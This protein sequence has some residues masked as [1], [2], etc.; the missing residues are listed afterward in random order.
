MSKRNATWPFAATAIVCLLAAGI[1]VAA[2]RARE[3]QYAIS[4]TNLTRAQIIS[5]VT[6]FTHT[7]DAEPLFSIGS[8]ASPAL[9]AVA[10]DADASGLMETLENDPDV[11]DIATLTGAEGPLMPGETA[12]VTMAAT[13][14]RQRVSLAGMLVTTND[15]FI[16][17]S[18]RVLPRGNW[19]VP[20]MI[21][22]YDA[23]SEAN[24]EDCDHIPGPPCGHGG[25]RV[26]DGAEGYVHVHAGIHGQGSLDPA[27]WDWRNPVARVVI[28]RLN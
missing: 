10:E 9:A 23:G 18:G 7:G 13:A 8:A 5:P 3:H 20:L 17:L 24:T 6:V 12:Q 28:R 27:E 26:T 21:P 11:I 1:A 25:V 15:A 22:A 19:D 2:P 16:G 14:W 4:I